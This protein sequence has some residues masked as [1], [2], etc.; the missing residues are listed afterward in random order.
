[1]DFT[2]ISYVL[3]FVYVLNFFVLMYL[4][5]V[6]KD[7]K[8]LKYWFTSSVFGV[9]AFSSIFLKPLIGNYTAFLNNGF[10]LVGFIIM[11][12]GLFIYRG[13][14]SNKT[15]KAIMI[16]MIVLVFLMSFLNT[17]DA[18]RRY[19]MYDLVLSG[20]LGTFAVLILYKRKEHFM[21]FL[22]PAGAAVLLILV[23]IIRWNLARL[24]IIS[25]YD[26]IHPIVAYAYFAGVIFSLTWLLTIL[27]MIQR[28]YIK[29]LEY[30]AS[31][32]SLTFLKNR[33]QFDKELSELYKNEEDRVLTIIDIN[34]FKHFNDQYG[35][36]FGDELLITVARMID[37]TFTDSHT[38]R[39]GGDEFCLITD[40]KKTLTE[41]NMFILEELNKKIDVCNTTISLSVS[42]GSSS[43]KDHNSIESLYKAA[44]A[45]MYMM[46]K[47]HDIR[48]KKKR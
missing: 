2:S 19:L 36:Q 22:I 10:I 5:G 48:V 46:K 47:N 14:A 18:T 16:C 1:M 28:D 8:G 11:I 35:H 20:L 43:T 13:Y 26:G 15:R 12:E 39:T 23:H 42:I 37:K 32:D 44:D 17:H 33:R 41:V 6:N 9:L 38:F 7:I 3:A 34:R 4:Y 40:S 27:L 29:Q 24:G 30:F 45:E 21:L 25:G 31:Y